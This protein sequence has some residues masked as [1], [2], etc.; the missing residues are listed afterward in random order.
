MEE[1]LQSIQGLNRI[2]TRSNRNTATGHFRVEEGYDPQVVLEEIKAQIDSISSFPDGMERPKVERIK[3]RQ[4]VLYI[5]LYGDLTPLQLKELG[6]K[7][8][9]QIRLLPGVNISEFYG[10]LDY[11]IAIEVSKDKLREFGL[12]FTDVANVIRGFSQN[13]SAGQIRSVNGY[14]NLRVQNQAY[15]GAEFADLPLITL[16]DGSKILLSDI[17]TISDGFEQGI[18]YSKFNGKN[19]VTFFVGA[20]NNQSIT[21][22]AQVVKGYIQDKQQS[23]PEGVK[24]EPWVD[25]TYYLQGRLDL[26][27]NSMKT[28]ALLVFILLA[29][30]LRVRLAFWV[31][32]GLP[33]CFLGTLL[34]LPTA[35]ID[36]TVNIVSLFAFILVLGIVVDDAIV[37]GESAHHEC[38]EK[39]QGLDNVLLGVKRVAMP[40]VFGVLTTIAA[41]LP[42]TMGDGPSSAFAKSI[43]FVVILCLIFSLI[44]SKLILPAH[45]ASMK[46]ETIVKPGSNN[47]FDWLRNIVNFLQNRVD[48]FLQGF[49]ENIY[50]PLLSKVLVYRYTVIML[51]ISLL[52]V[53]AGLYQGGFVRYIGQPK[54]PHDFPQVK[55]EMNSDASEKSTLQAALQV[56]QAILKVDREL[57][58]Q[59]GQKMIADMHVRLKGRVEAEIMSKLV[60]PELRPINTFQLAELWRNEIPKI[61]GL[62]TLKVRDHLYGSEREDDDVNFRLQGKDPV[63][64]LSAAN[65]LA[66]KLKSLQG[67]SDVTSSHESSSKEVQFKL[68]P[69]AKSL[70]VTLKDLAEQVGYSFYGLEAQRLLRNGD[71]IKVMLRYPQAQRNAIGLVSDVLI[72]TAQ[73]GEIPL[74]ELA[75]II[76]TDG[77]N[78]IRRED[79]HR[80]ISVWGAVDAAQVE[81]LKLAQDIRE[82]FMPVL[83]KKYPSVQSRV[84]G[85]IQEEIESVNTQIRNFILALL[86]IYTLLAV[87]L[88]S[89]AQ[90]F[91]IMAVIPFGIIGSVLGHMIFGLDLSILSLFGIIAVAGVVVNDSLIMVDYINIARG[92]G[93]NMSDAVV[94]AG[95][96]RFRAILLTS[97][98][99]FIGLMP[100]MSET[101]MQAKMV[102]PMAVSL[103]FGVMFATLVTLL[104]IPC[105]YIAIEDIKGL[106]SQSIL[107]K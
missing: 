100:I 65:E 90:P 33:I 97:L 56:E 102:I 91:M 23:L 76:I 52:L 77:L 106:Y 50:Q 75:D 93:I 20:T 35:M 58:E 51:F 107:C 24:L 63:S 95:G 25:M 1:A 7:V 36:V 69:L 60:D 86:I 42:I 37:I 105:L 88:K 80:T 103:A 14:I 40:A 41:F 31:M 53:A 48:R 45:L 99:T 83:L 82:N 39:G 72:Q 4:E 73:G 68:K 81:P 16:S 104:L 29:L 61:A 66:D 13:M 12:S 55:L 59:Y 89:Y 71:E 54:V 94:Q 64:L 17:A 74:S 85:R 19:S 98:T 6:D 26:M 57:E 10:G 92:N 44:E 22:V 43:G 101:S 21:D 87:P 96:R 46:A 18:Q 49:V 9:E 34:F 79:G 5:S 8:H 32:M 2:I 38:A 11:E 27:F 67:V 70:E 84:A 62:K 78:S 15:V 47:P 30:F 28:G 3:L